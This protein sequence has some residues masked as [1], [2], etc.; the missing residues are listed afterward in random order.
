VR[1]SC[2]ASG[3]T[4]GYNCHISGQTVDFNN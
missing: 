4:V 2:N 3:L 1:H